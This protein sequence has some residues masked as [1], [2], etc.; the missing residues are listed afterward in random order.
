MKP[1][2]VPRR[3]LPIALAA[4]T[5]N[6]HAG[7]DAIQWPDDADAPALVGAAANARL[8]V[9]VAIAD[10][11][12]DGYGDL[13]VGATGMNAAF[14]Y[15]GGADGLA[16][17]AAMRVDAPD[18]Q[19]LQFG[20]IASAGDVNHDGYADAIIGAPDDRTTS[21]SNPGAAYLYLG[22]PQGLSPSPTQRLAP[23]AGTTPSRFGQAAASAGDVNG[24]GYDDVLVAA[25]NTSARTSEY[26]GAVYLY[27]GRR[28]GVAARPQL[29]TVG[30]PGAFFG[31]SVGGADL[32]GDG[33]SDVL[34]GASRYR[35][36]TVG[37]AAFVFRGRRGH[38]VDPA[39]AARYEVDFPGALFGVGIAPAGDVDGDGYQDLVV[40]GPGNG[41]AGATTG[42]V[43]V[44]RGGPGPLATT[45]LFEARGTT[46][47]ALTG[48]SVASAGDIDGDGDDDIAYG[49]LGAV[50][51]GGKYYGAVFSVNDLAG[52]PQ[53]TPVRVDPP[54]GPAHVATSVGAAVASGD[55][56][57]DG[58][59][60]IVSG[61]NTYA[62]GL[63]L[64]GGVFI[65]WGKDR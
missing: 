46:F 31:A 58:I 6:A 44:Y 50:R 3:I 65:D 18:P 11:N 47:G 35:E 24:D 10:V 43:R 34:V 17:D 60:E 32:D 36:A 62:D 2:L 4:C 8:G 53:S 57:G 55:L 49:Q 21:A 63:P 42:W 26:M 19:A 29:L 13:L 15:P 9:T 40:G 23:L 33:F 25:P 38:G 45:P 37:G 20:Y 27:L 51:A 7:L 61:A 39:P 22:S 56:D 41:P 59:P 54:G 28:D 52:A 14:V 30:E 1:V 12:G 16:T 5:A 48:F 64:Q